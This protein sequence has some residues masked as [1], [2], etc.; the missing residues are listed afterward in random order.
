MVQVQGNLMR[1]LRANTIAFLHLIER[2]YFYA[3]YSSARYDQYT[4]VWRL[5]KC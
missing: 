3:V 5:Q 1:S 2:S 4:I